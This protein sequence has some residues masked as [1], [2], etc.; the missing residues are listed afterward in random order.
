MPNIG[1]F[2]W[3]D[4]GIFLIIAVGLLIG[5]TQGLL[6]Q[7]IGLA[8][9]Y[10]ATIV[11]TQYYVAVSNVI[12]GAFFQ[13]PSRFA[14]VVAF[15]IIFFGISAI[16]NL[17]AADAYQMTKL[18]IFPTIDQLGGSFI[19]LVT[20]IILLVLLL[21][22]LMFVLVEPLPYFD[23]FREALVNGLDSSRLVPIFISFRRD[24]LNAIAPWLPNGQIPSI[25]NL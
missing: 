2:N 3:V 19:G 20:I 24:L 14:S 9:L 12:N 21:P 8:S 10:L 1:Y 23:N 13:A 18:R 6:L 22:I 5:Y 17:L 25:F 15:L 4:T 11:A 16:I 7:V